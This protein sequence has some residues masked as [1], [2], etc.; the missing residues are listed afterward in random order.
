MLG[1][2]LVVVTW[3]GKNRGRGEGRTVG[4]EARLLSIA[5]G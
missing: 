1:F 5:E 3:E 4:E 2:S